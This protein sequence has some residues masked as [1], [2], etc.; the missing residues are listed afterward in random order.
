MATASAFGC[1][2]INT[3]T[4]GRETASSQ[5]PFIQE[6]TAPERW[7]NAYHIP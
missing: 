2:P 6:F 1:L 7:H 5:V 4:A 3:T